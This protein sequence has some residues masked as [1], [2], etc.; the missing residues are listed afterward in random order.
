MVM[1][2]KVGEKEIF[3]LAFLGRLREIVTPMLD[4]EHSGHD[5]YHPDRVCRL[6]LRLQEHEGGDRLIIGVAAFLHD[7]HRAMGKDEGRFISPAESLGLVK[8]IIS[9]AGGLPQETVQSILYC[10]EHHEEY[11]FGVE[12]KAEHNLETRIVQDADNLDSIGAIGIG[13][14]FKYAG[15]HGIAMHLPDLEIDA[16]AAYTDAEDGESVIQHIH[17]KMLRIPETLNT[18]RAKQIADRRMDFVRSFL[19][20]FSFEWNQ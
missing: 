8:R 14:T 2:S 19:H 17:R 1:N 9:Q 13:R 16:G 4:G 10:I 18:L 12:A 11:S 15:N 5:V 6:A 3:F 20:E 7:M